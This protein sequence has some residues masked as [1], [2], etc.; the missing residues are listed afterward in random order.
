MLR[1]RVTFR[2]GKTQTS[3]RDTYEMQSGAAAGETAL[4]N[5]GWRPASNAIGRWRACLD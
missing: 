4:S 3:P 2:L 1:A 5:A